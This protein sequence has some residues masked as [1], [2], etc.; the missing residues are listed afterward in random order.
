MVY[1]SPKMGYKIAYKNVHKKV[2][3][4]L[5]LDLIKI[6]KKSEKHGAI[7]YRLTSVGILYTI[8]RSH[9]HTEFRH[10]V[11]NYSNDEIFNFLL[12]P[13]FE[14]HTI[15]SLNS[16]TIHDI[17]LRYLEDCW[18]SIYSY[19][20]SIAIDSRQNMVLIFRWNMIPSNDSTKNI[21]IIKYLRQRFE[22]NWLDDNALLEKSSDG[23]ELIITSGK[24]ALIIKLNEDKSKATLME[25]N[26][27]IFE[28]TVFDIGDDLEI[29]EYTWLDDD[30]LLKEYEVPIFASVQRHA[31]NLSFTL[32]SLD[33]NYDA[34]TIYP[35]E[36][37]LRREQKE[38]LMQD[39]NL[40][41]ND[42]KFLELCNYFYKEFQKY[43]PYFEKASRITS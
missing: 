28:F 39:I 1:K 43:E 27:I 30:E 13:Y 20:Y 24:R 16:R 17:I 19:V 33:E 26:D 25:N 8:T 32:I 6:V 2:I 12:Y 3:K 7:Y 42:K 34:Q 38:K 21:D 9:F 4:L 14:K 37:W 36:K 31:Q 22:L 41:Q 35:H 15:R 5:N 11:D 29:N 23:K 40:I 10:L 18:N